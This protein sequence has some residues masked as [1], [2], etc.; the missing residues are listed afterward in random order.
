M[1]YLEE[2]TSNV[3]ILVENQFP[4]FIQKTNE[5]FL[6]F[7]SSY[8]ESQES[9]Y[10]PL[11]IALNLVD[12]YNIGYYRPN[13]LVQSTV[14]NESSN[15]SST[16]TTINVE[17][18]IGFPDKNGYIQIND[19]IIFYREKTETS[20]LECVRGTSALVLNSIPKSNIVLTSST[21]E[22]HLNESVVKNIAYN[23]AKEFLKRI[24][25]ELAPLIPEVLDESLDLSNFIKNIKSFYSSKGSLNSH[26]ILFKILFNDRK[27]NIILKNRGSGAKLKVNNSRGFIVDGGVEIED[28]GSGYDNRTENG[29]LINPPVV[30]VFG[31][32]TGTIDPVTKTRPNATA[33]I[34]IDGIDSNGSITSTNIV[35]PGESYRGPLSTRVRNRIF[36]ED[37]LVKNISGTGSGR[38][39][40]YDAFTNEIILYDVIGY[41]LP[42]EE[43]FTEDGEQAR[44][45]IAQSYTSPAISRNGLEII[46]ENQ[47]I[48]FPKEY[49]FKTSNAKYSKKQII[50]CRLIDGYSL[51]DDE[52]PKVVSLIQDSDK[53]FGV[54]GVSIEVDNSISLSDKIYQFD[55]G[56]NSDIRN[57]FLPPSTVIT[58]PLTG[59]SSSTSEFIVTVDE[60]TRF[61]V[62]NGIFFVKGK[63]IFYT[64]R[65]VNQF[66]GCSYSGTDTFDLGVKDEV[67]S[68][69]RLK[70]NK[71]WTTSTNID[72]GEYVFYGENYY[73][74]KNSGIT[75]STPPTHTSGSEYDGTIVGNN[76][77][78]WEFI[79]KNRLDHTFYIN[80]N[81][82]LIENP[83]FQ[84][85]GLPGEIVIE[86][87]GALHSF[88]NYDFAKF[89]S[90]NVDAYNF[91]TSEI[92]DRL[93]LVLGTNYNRT[94]DSVIEESTN[95][96][97]EVNNIKTLPSY[98]SL[99]G[100][101]NQYDF[102]DYIYVAGSGIPRWW[103]DIVDY[104]T[105]LSADDKKKVAFTNQKLITRWKKSGLISDTQAIGL[106]RKTKKLLGLN[107]DAIQANSYKGNT[108][109][110][111][112]IEKFFIGD[113]G[114]YPVVYQ[115]DNNGYGYGVDFSAVPDLLLSDGTKL[116]STNELVKI[117]AE[118]KSIDFNS[119]A[120][121]WNGTTST[122]DNL[123]NFTTKP[124]IEVINNNDR[125]LLEFTSFSNINLTDNKITYTNHGLKTL[126]KVLYAPFEDYFVNLIPGTEYFARKIDD[127]TFTLHKTK[128]D[129]L[130]NINKLNLSYYSVLNPQYNFISSYLNPPYFR[131]A[132][133]D[134]SYKNGSIDNIIIRN[135]GAGY[136]NLPTI[137]ISGGGKT[138]GG[139]EWYVDIPFS[140]NGKRI[141]EASGP[142]VSYFDYYKDN[143]N[144]LT[145]R[146]STSDGFI[147][148]STLYD[149][150]P[151]VSIDFGSGGKAVAYTANGVIVSVVIIDQGSGYK[152][153][154]NVVIT[155]DGKDAVITSK[156]SNGKLSGFD[157]VNGGSGYIQSPRIDIVSRELKG[158]LISSKLKE[159]TFNLVRQLNKLDRIDS[160]GGYVYDSSDS[161]P[162]SNNPK[163]FKL[164][165]YNLDFPRDIDQKQYYL[166][167]NSDKLLAK[168]ILEKSPT[169]VVTAVETALGKTKDQFTDNEILTYFVVHSPAIMISYDGIPVYGGERILGERNKSLITDTTNPNYATQFTKAK[170]RYKLKYTEVLAG[171]SGAIT[172]STTDGTKYVTLDRSGG[173]SIDQYP[174]G[175]F[176]EDY[177]F[178]QGNDDDLDIHNGRFS[179]TPEFPQGR[180]CYFATSES[181]DPI[182]NALVESVAADN[183]SIGFNGF[184]Y[185]IGDEYASE[186]DDYMNGICRT[187]NKIPS[188]FTRSFEKDIDPIIQNGVTLFPG[189]EHNDEYP[190][191]DDSTSKTIARTSTVSSGS[192]DSVIVESK[193]DEY[194][195]GDRLVINNELTSGSGF[196]AIV[197]KVGGKN[198]IKLERKLSNKRVVFTTQ[199]EHGLSKNDFV[200]FEYTK[201]STPIQ[202]NLQNNFLGV[203]ADENRIT[204]ISDITV[205]NR[206]LNVDRYKDIVF[207]EI[208]LNFK[209]T[210]KLN[211][212][213]NTSVQLTYD[214][215]KTNEFFTLEDSPANSIVLN[216]VNIP[217]RLYLHVE[218]RIYQINKTRD[219]YGIQKVAE[220]TSKTFTIDFI[221]TTVGYETVNLSYTAKSFGAFGPIEEVSITNQGFGYK[222]LPVV[223]KIIK[224]GTEDEIAGNGKAIIQTNSNTI[225]SLK[226]L[227]YSCFGRSFTANRNVNYYL[228]IPATAK[229]TKN[230]EIYDI[231]ILNGGSNYD[232]VVTL[233]VNGQ[234]NLATLEATVYLGTITN[235]KVID[236]G[237]NFESEPTITVQSTYGSGAQFKSK[238]RRKELYPGVKLTGNVNSLLFPVG[239]ETDVVSFDS[240]SSTLEFNENVGQFKDGDK[241]YFEGKVY[242]EIQSIRRSKAYAKVNAFSELDI[243]RS[244]ISG[245]T[246][247]NLQ[248]LTD[249]NYYQDWSYSISSTRDTKDWIEEQSINTHPAGF[250]QFGKK[251]IERRKFFFKNPL[252][253]FKSSVIFSTN[254]SRTL[255]LNLKISPC[256]K[257]RLF[258]FDVTDFSVGQYVVGSFS[259]ANGKIIEITEGTLIVE[260]YNNIQFILGEVVVGV[261]SDFVFGIQDATLRSLNFWNGIFQEPDESYEV[262]SDPIS[263]VPHYTVDDSDEISLYTFD[264]DY[265]R[266]DNQI[267][268]ATQTSFSLT[269]EN[270][271]YPITSAILNELM[272]VIGGVVQ[273]PSNL[274]VSNNSI[275]LPQSVGYET[276]VITIRHDKL[277]KLTL[278]GS[279]TTYTLNYTPSDDCQLLIFRTGIFQTHLFTD[280]TVSGNTLTLSESIP[281]NELFGWYFDGTVNCQEIDGSVINKNTVLKEIPCKKILFKQFIES[282]AVK[283]PESIYE[284]RKE[285]IDGT[286]FPVSST[287][288]EGFDTKFSYTSPRTS[289][290]YVEVLDQITFDG[291]TQSFT[292]KRTKENYTPK[293]GEE[294]LMVY[295]NDTVLDYDQY[296]V[297][298]NTITFNTAYS[299]STKCTLLDFVSDYTSNTNNE[300]G[301]IIDRLEVKQNGTRST[302][303]LS[304][305]GVPKYVNN[306]GDIFVIKNDELQY[307][308]SSYT[309]HKYRTFLGHTVND[310]K[311]TFGNAPSAS[312]NVNL[313]FFN[314]QL[315]PEPTKNVVLDPFVCFD[316]TRTT[317]PITLDGI[318]FTPVSVYHLFVVRNGVM[319]TPTKDYTV[320]GSSIT[321]T[322]APE[323]YEDELIFTFYS[324]DGLNQNIPLSIANYVDGVETE[325][326]LTK[327]YVSTTVLDNHNLMMYRNG[328]YQ[329]PGKDYTVLDG[330]SAP[331]IR[332]TTAPTVNDDI[333]MINIRQ[334]SFDDLT[335]SFVQSSPSTIT[336]STGSQV[337]NDMFFIFVNG[338]LQVGT[339]YSTAYASSQYTITFG[340]NVNISTDNVKIYAF[341]TGGTSRKELDPIVVTNTSTLSY[342]LA[343]GG[344]PITNISG[345]ADIIVTIEGVVQEP[346][347]AYTIAGSTLTFN[348]TALYQTGITINIFQVG[349]NSITNPNESVDYID[350]NYAKTTL[351]EN[352]VVIKP[353]R[354]KLANGFQSF[355]PPNQDDLF[356]IRNGVVQNPTEDF[357]IG[358]GYIEFTTNIAETED[359]FIMYTH[360]TEELT[361]SSSGAV[362][363]SIHRYTLSSPVPFSD[364]N[365][366]V[367]YADG[368]PRFYRRGDFTIE[369]N[370][371]EIHLSHTEGFTPTQVFIVEYPNVTLIDDYQ[372]CPN[373]SRTLFKLRYNDQNL[374]PADILEDADILVSQ[375]GVVLNPDTEYDIS[376]NRALITFTTAPAH[377]DVIFM[378]RMSRNELRTLT[379]VSGNTY[380]LSTAEPI[381]KE[382]VVVF[383]NN[384]WNFAETGGFT[385][386][387]AGTQITL[388][389]PHTTGELFAIKFFGVFNRLDQIHTPF[390]GSNTKFNLYDTEENFVPIGTVNNDNVPDETSM[391]VTK[392]GKL[393]EPKVD[394]TLDGDIKSQI[395][396]NSAPSSSDVISIRNVGMFDKLDVITGG[397]GTQFPLTKSGVD[398]YPN[399]HIERPREL[400]NQ[401]IVLKDGEVQSP[402]YDFYV[403]NNKIVFV[404]SV[405]F[406]KLVI[407]D[408][409]GT[410][411][412][413]RVLNRFNQVSVGD[414][415]RISGEENA[416]KVTSVLSPTVLTTDSYVG[417]SPGNFTATT[418]YSN[419]VVTDFTMTNGGG[420]YENPVVI[421]TKGT[422]TSAKAVAYVKTLIGD[423]IVDD[424]TIDIQYPGNNIYTNQT[425]VATMYATTYKEQPLHKSTILKATKL[426][427]SINATDEIIPLANTSGMKSN[428]PSITVSSSSGAGADFKI[429]VSNNEIAKIE[430]LNGGSGYDDRDLTLELIGGGGTGCVLEPVLDG[431]GTITDVIIR[432]SGVGY[433]T[434]KVILYYENSGV[435]KSETIEYTYVNSN[436]IDGCTRASNAVSHDA[437]IE[438]PDVSST[439]TL[440]YFEDHDDYL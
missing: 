426:S 227:S 47:N 184:P 77:V 428:A 230:F 27:F 301:A 89:D 381:E 421:R 164:I 420:Y 342:S 247:E 359:L 357:I 435:V 82:S 360:G 145:A 92:S 51:P 74:A 312:D 371:T 169:S 73:R 281:A 427:S 194:R 8:Y 105:T 274:T 61:P 282:N 334:N 33:I 405:S 378:V 279:G 317:F 228:D 224:K 4:D 233:L 198:L 138:S 419:G 54:P 284:I 250:K 372:Y 103:D 270:A 287:R 167:Q 396:F 190:Q 358:N 177:E 59:I 93:S 347:V 415:L 207:Y 356:I 69:A 343:D 171:T 179:I 118:I 382:N 414:E 222:K 215:E 417:N 149:I 170:S 241:I 147:P 114:D 83:K 397:T 329:V 318:S 251:I 75:G 373:G 180:Y 345:P 339:A 438:S 376:T 310:N 293:N 354:Y 234:N 236:G 2:K 48:E 68:A 276:K 300:N 216:A 408:F 131:K 263:Y 85:L 185:F 290:S 139:Q 60:A 258:L 124:R 162:S 380:S 7:V 13:R 307:P 151:S 231:E 79:G 406:T 332:F 239:I 297:S 192:V 96:P 387:T 218:N 158:S 363:S 25:S 204:E 23:Y 153:P 410:S 22:E 91:T 88:S 176:I 324:Y 314:R 173:P 423:N 333:F 9:K 211:L 44:G 240:R 336:Y 53:I 197:S 409:R 142:L 364:Y 209:Y 66:F 326:A 264:N 226:K 148:T 52:L 205:D 210:Y 295:I 235:V 166:L 90:P 395:V 107:I 259:G 102:E 161:V 49:T 375:N 108:I 425:A 19:E 42:N 311:I 181:Y 422:G 112:Q 127:N 323:S 58:K 200:Y 315:V 384:K 225:G 80:F 404:N 64:S 168:Y 97:L 337:D 121:I 303:N 255:D 221:E 262:A 132:Q 232:N 202:I 136:I 1:K 163:E 388:T 331:Y 20:F 141:I 305:R 71:E 385:W 72:I 191:Q 238:I 268:S 412:D 128:S 321:F 196:S 94:R 203:G 253:V 392:N 291:S 272:I 201:P 206:D 104:N 292:L 172:L 87:G 330:S 17:S 65:S 398:Y 188:V 99:T 389:T 256:G 383:S 286:V 137:R 346:G 432:N 325:F 368:V 146:T 31:S 327:D 308:V 386:N 429:F 130:L 288:V 140:I 285:T 135:S 95:T 370:D 55:I 45:F 416:R 18:T 110:Y 277:K 348:A 21:A 187:N 40:Y 340:S 35:D 328:V 29:K 280:F 199:T 195:V 15:L 249:S 424:S 267:L 309:D 374:V 143:Y 349:D 50:K 351:T 393:L 261:N 120:N 341:T 269:L 367:V 246:S 243:E 223:E 229:V 403:D 57:I 344:T 122:K 43:I 134:L 306:V 244:N 70:E 12:Y 377:N 116:G 352:G 418:T 38:V 431:S 369:N 46:G 275:V 178:V 271:S 115:E 365:N 273:D 37:Q 24:K 30:D 413:V 5:K 98:Q 186:Y 302:F 379:N 113:G 361:I 289:G 56:T 248:K 183:D 11:D 437:K 10:Q 283:K 362:S 294:S 411:N 150:A 212:P 117:S 335:S 208:N 160:Y 154:P 165:D 16:A 106:G 109:S 430:I 242:G 399:A 391:L 182:T 439:Y 394:F 6:N 350:D 298:G 193:G 338:I 156:I 14:L 252:D 355:N 32:G 78:S 144:E 245:N 39:E 266:L 219:F 189:L 433:D 353:T 86:N 63:E 129:A 62:S 260:N 152:L 407:L 126:D 296:S 440:V 28:G 101:S 119:L 81:N 436:N 316:G 34:E 402:L 304:D 111:G 214:I 26:R 76:P 133:L 3:S 254:I 100:F 125:A 220:T 157:I 84:L 159:W 322:T 174:I 67:I 265:V 320:S 123:N 366:I 257:Q 278:T 401:L 299:S 217:N 213:A 400:E 313:V 175:S 36:R 41:F 319:Q 390:N 434:Y 155:G 237:L